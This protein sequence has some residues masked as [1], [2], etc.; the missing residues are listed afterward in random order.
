MASLSSHARCIQLLNYHL[1]LVFQ[2]KPRLI[3]KIS[4]KYSDFLSI[5]MKINTHFYQ[6]F[7]DFMIIKNSR[8]IMK[9]YSIKMQY[10][11]SSQMFFN[12]YL[13]LTNFDI[14]N[15]HSQKLWYNLPYSFKAKGKENFQYAT[16]K[17]FNL[18]RILKHF[19]I[20][21]TMLLIYYIGT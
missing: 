14:C 20:I 18:I 7:A 2:L 5:H 1:L 21:I 10:V 13:E 6:E 12:I 19:T 11:S 9:C 15:N 17:H 16:E 3:F 8:N 4:L